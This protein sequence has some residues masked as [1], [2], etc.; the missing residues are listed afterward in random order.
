MSCS[1][2]FSTQK[3]N[4]RPLLSKLKEWPVDLII[5]GYHGGGM[6]DEST[7]IELRKDSGVVNIRVDG[8]ENRYVFT[9]GM[10]ELNELIVYFNNHHFDQIEEEKTG[11]IIYDAPST[12]LSV[13]YGRKNISLSEGSTTSTKAHTTGDFAA[14]YQYLVSYVSGKTA[15]LK[16]TICF[17]IHPDIRKK[18]GQF[19]ILPDTGNESYHGNAADIPERF[20]LSLLKGVHTFQFHRTEKDETGRLQYRASGYPLFELQ[21]DTVISVSEKDG[22]FVFE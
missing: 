12:S 5:T 11:D 22:A 15:H 8:N 6:M 3:N 18:T 16:R 7:G 1:N 17:I 4:D 9:P 2:A 10:Q 13:S 21:H 20:C 19:S 14:C